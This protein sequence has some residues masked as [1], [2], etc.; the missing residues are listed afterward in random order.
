MSAQR[1]SIGAAPRESETESADNA[2]PFWEASCSATTVEPQWLRVLSFGVASFVAA[3]GAVGLALADI[4]QYRVMLVV[5]V[6]LLLWM[7]VL[8][9]ARPILTEP[10]CRSVPA[11]ALSAVAV[12]FVVTIAG[13]HALNA[14]QHVL[15]NRDGGVYANAGRWIAGHGNLRVP[16]PFGP[17]AGQPGLT[18]ASFGMYPGRD[19]SLSFQFPHLLPAVLA[20]A[21]G[22]GGDHLMFATP[23]LLAGAAL[24]SLFLLAWRLVR[25]PL[26]A[27]GVV[28]AFAFVIPEVSFSRDTYSEI[29]MQLLVFTA[30][31][32]LVQ[33]GAKLLQFA[34]R[35][36]LVAGFLLGLLQA[37]RVDA[38]AFLVGLP[39]LFAVAWLLADRSDRRSVS[40]G[41][42]AFAAG[43]L[44]AM[45]LGFADVWYRSHQYLHDLRV[46]V[47]GL[48]I[49]LTA[50]ALASLGACVIVPRIRWM[51]VNV[52]AVG[53]AA[54]AAVVAGG[55]AAWLVRPRIQVTRGITDG[56]VAGLQAAAHV[57]VDPTRT[58]YERSMQWMSWYLGPI[59]LTL[60]IIGA[61]LL[62]YALFRGAMFA[63]LPVLSVLG[64]GTMLYLWSAHAAPDQVW[65][66]RRFL[67]TA[68]PLLVLLAF[69]V[70]ALLAH[71]VSRQIP[72]TVSIAVAV[73]VGLVA[74]AYPMTSV[75]HV[76]RMSEQRGDL[77]VINDVCRIVG[78]NGVVLL[79]PESTS[80][81]STWIPQTL[82]GWCGVPVAIATND[83]RESPTNLRAL[84]LAWSKAGRTLWL[85]A[86][87]PGTILAALPSARVVQTRTG[88]NQYFLERTLVTRPNHY[89]VERFAVAL[90]PVPA[91]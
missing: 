17:F 8:A 25:Q 63:A 53:T 34:P 78:H 83:F 1:G 85:G 24:L 28:F 22:I 36:A 19:G 9:V 46:D 73:V 70:V 51:R 81:V 60:A 43:L 79:L 38:I 6:G 47:R 57:S 50:S 75:V 68:F 14:S 7:G 52:S 40:L 59:T 32:I 42:L 33:P 45:I 67:A 5:P 29:L 3:F 21:R 49:A 66:T 87:A 74:V 90:A 84:A 4:G 72:G 10:G 37:T 18:T 20:E 39:P 82:R 58:Y 11:H 88:V 61:G 71:G 23:A 15:I 62:V 64:P 80:L 30:L 27:L 35:V 91:V 2:K 56:L 44:P 86:G 55:F 69:G 54:G 26:L 12:G 89:V 16:A 76:R 41:A 48:A 13:W 65:V 77:A 31:W